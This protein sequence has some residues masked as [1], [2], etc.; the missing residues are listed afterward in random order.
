MAVIRLASRSAASPAAALAL[1][2]VFVLGGLIA[3]GLHRAEHAAEWAAERTAHV[4]QHHTG[5]TAA[6][7]PCAPA[8]RDL[9]CALCTGLSAF[10]PVATVAAFQPAL[11]AAPAPSVLTALGA[12]AAVDARPRAPPTA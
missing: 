4:A 10:A 6:D 5:Q 3:P 8:V 1:A 7:V 12:D 2:V 11:D 9:D